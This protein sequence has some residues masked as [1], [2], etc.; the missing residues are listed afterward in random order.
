VNTDWILTLARI[1]EWPATLIVVLIIFQRPLSQLILRVRGVNSKLVS[2]VFEIED[3]RQ[4]LPS[5]KVDPDPAVK[6]VRKTLRLPS[7]TVEKVKPSLGE[8]REVHE[9]QTVQ[10]AI[11]EAAWKRLLAA[12]GRFGDTTQL[13]KPESLQAF[14]ESLRAS[15]TLNLPVVKAIAKLAALRDNLLSGV[16]PMDIAGSIA[17]DQ[18]IDDIVFI[19]Q[20][21]R[22]HNGQS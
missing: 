22:G 18:A 3:I 17:F 12:L 16:V 21:Q 11:I 10:N 20:D 15:R 6:E 14:L 8:I 2:V 19:L 7:K 5:P 9:I 13:A 1:L 4:T